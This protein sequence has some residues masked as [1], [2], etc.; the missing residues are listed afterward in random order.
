VSSSPRRAVVVGLG[1]SGAAC[2]RVLS[3]EGW[4]VEV[5]DSGDTVRARELAAGLPHD[6]AVT[7]GGYSPEVVDGAELVCP[8]PA[9]PWG[10]PELERARAAGIPVRSEIDLTFERCPSPIVGVTGTNGK[11]TTTALLG[12][13]LA[14]GGARV[15]VGGNIGL[16]MLDLLDGVRPD[17][18]VVLE[19]SS[20]QL[21]SASKPRCRLATVLNIG[22]DHLDRHGTME[23]YIA[24]K[25]RLVEHVDPGGAVALNAADPEAMRMAAA[26]TARVLRFALDRQLLDGGDGTAVVDATVAWIEGG[27]VTPVVPVAEIPLF[28][29]HNHENVLAAVALARAAGVA[30]TALR[31]AVRGFTAV[32]HR[33]QTVAERDGVLWVND[34]KATN[35]DAAV[36]A[37]RSFDRPV[38]WIGGGGRKGVG[39]ERLVAEVNARARHA[40]LQ[41]ATAAE[42]DQA[43]A[44]LGY[45]ERT[46]V[47]DLRA[48][49]EAAAAVARPGDVVL[50]APGY[51]SFDQHASY[52]ERGRLFGELVRG[53][54]TPAGRT[55]A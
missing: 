31:D 11:T 40:I 34:S 13:L 36:V 42:L 3:A 4:S 37:L 23:A 15:H 54:P 10:A 45:A 29:A 51:T 16:P 55:S 25:R 48:A 50:L 38:I 24:A 8:S 18:W 21:E 5:V 28:G 32:E 2:A 12:A 19:L 26:T 41:G 44:Q 49:V 53:L 14:A 27:V 22:P 1:R 35:V 52:E 33:L 39:P 46:V 43:L 30:A 47:A 17:D 6:V 9:V 20:F 7:L